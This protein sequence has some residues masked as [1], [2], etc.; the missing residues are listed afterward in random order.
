MFLEPLPLQL[1]KEY[2]LNVVKEIEATREFQDLDKNVKK[3]SIEESLGRKP[4]ESS[5]KDNFCFFFR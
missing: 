5:Y 2:K 3:C 4:L 1:G